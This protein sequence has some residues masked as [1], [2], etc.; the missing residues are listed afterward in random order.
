MLQVESSTSSAKARLLQKTDDD[1][2]VVAAVRSAIAKGRKGGFKDTRPEE[3]LTGMSPSVAVL[4]PGGGAGPA[5]MA[6]LAAGIPNTTAVNAVNRQCSSGLTA[7]NQIANEIKTGQIDIGIGAGVESM[8]HGYGA[9]SQPD[10]YSDLVL[11]CKEAEDCL[12]PMGI[13]S[14]NVAKDYGITRLEQDKFAAESFRRA[15]VAIKAGKFRDEIVPLK[16]K[17]IDPK[18]EEEKSIV[19][20]VDEG[21]RDGV[22][23]ESL[24]KLKPAFTKDGT[25]HAG[26]AS[27]V[28]DGAAAV[29]LAR[30]SVAKRLGLPILGKFNNAAVVGVPPRV[31]GI[32]PA[33]AIP[34]ALKKAG[35][36][37]SD[38]DFYE[39]NEAFASQ[40]VYC[41]RELGIPFEKVN[42]HGGAIAIGH[43]LGCTGARQVA[44]GYNISKQYGAKV[45]VTSMCIGSG[46]DARTTVCLD[47][48][49]MT[50]APA[51]APPAK[52]PRLSVPEH[53]TI[54][55]SQ[56]YFDD[57]SIALSAHEDP[58]DQES[59]VFVF[60]VHASMLAREST[61]FADMM[62]LSATS[63]DIQDT[64]N[65]APLVHLHDRAE[66]VQGFLRAIYDP[67]K[68][69]ANEYSAKAIDLLSGPLILAHKYEA[70]AIKDCVV[71]RLHDDW[72]LNNFKKWTARMNA[73][74]ANDI[75]PDQMIHLSHTS[76]ARTELLLPLS[77]AYYS[78]SSMPETSYDYS[79]LTSTDVLYAMAGR[80]YMQNWIC[81]SIFAGKRHP[82]LMHC[83]SCNVAR[84][85]KTMVS[86]IALDRTSR[87]LAHWSSMVSL[88]QPDVTLDGFCSNKTCHDR[89]AA[90]LK[91]ILIKAYYMIPEFFDIKTWDERGFVD[92]RTFEPFTDKP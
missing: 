68:V 92:S 79:L 60:R 9:S 80:R 1:V 11:G 40:A 90:W 53:T 64:Y 85:T 89:A 22:T 69:F 59:I 41:V 13:T 87:S 2:V 84:Y 67:L 23:A 4:P 42:V 70:L 6:A 14:E 16:V 49:T 8:T 71:K 28:S 91:R 39:I 38:V 31:M 18:T 35:I 78:L 17:V 19:V 55:D 83:Y 86:N 37:V 73:T 21:V 57:G 7:I 24:G 72:P 54:Q 34:V 63:D 77:L 82:S 51:E 5:R 3:L 32:G 65:G 20:E 43:P 44:T 48:L 88:I 47:P 66:H 75:T 46:M 25:T 74:T 45:F 12:I 62:K 15:A 33:F 76:K 81:D 30:R 50:Q 26:N 29:L 61:V 27:Q 52:R 10:G 36:S 58:D 56:Y